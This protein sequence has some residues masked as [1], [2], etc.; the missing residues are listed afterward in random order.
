MQEAI[1]SA[2]GSWFIAVLCCAHVECPLHPSVL[3]HGRALHGM[4]TEGAHAR[5]RL[6]TPQHVMGM[7][8]VHT[9]TRTHKYKRAQACTRTPTYTPTLAHVHTHAYMYPLHVM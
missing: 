9:N 8:G 4:C 7:H 1:A 2:F 3:C 5:T 6:C